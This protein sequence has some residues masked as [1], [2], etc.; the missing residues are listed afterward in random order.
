MEGTTRSGA[1]YLREFSIDSNSD[2]DPTFN[3]NSD[4]D[5]S[6]ATMFD[7]ESNQGNSD[8]AT[9]IQEQVERT[10]TAMI[11]AGTPGCSCIFIKIC[12]LCY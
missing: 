2:S 9:Q 4:L 12:D 10:I 11:A 3:P 8:F 7:T 6:V 5:S 1:R